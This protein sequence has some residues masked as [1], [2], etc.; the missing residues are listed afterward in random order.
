MEADITKLDG[1]EG[2]LSVLIPRAL[3]ARR[4]TPPI[5]IA[6]MP[7]VFDNELDD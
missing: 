2:C 4:R 3:K 1:K 7:V 6:T 5:D